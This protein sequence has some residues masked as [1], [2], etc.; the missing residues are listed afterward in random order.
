MS[1]A[2]SPR[3][4]AASA[5]AMLAA[6]AAIAMPPFGSWSAPQNL[7]DLPGSAP[8][9]NTAAVDG[10]VSHD[11][12]GLTLYF[13]SNRD[14][15]HDI[16]M[17]Q[18]ADTSSGFGTPMK[19]PAPINS[20]SHNE[21]CPTIANGNRLYFSSDKDDPAYDLYVSKSGPKGWSAPANLGPNINRPGWLDE[22]ADFYEDEAGSEVMIFSSRSGPEGDIWQSVNGGMRELVPG[23]PHSS[24]SDNRP[25]VTKDGLTIFWD[26]N[27]SGGLGGQDLYFAT[28]SSTSQSFGTAQHLGTLSSPGFDA[29]PVVSW[30]GTFLTFSSQRAGNVSPAPD[31]WIT[32]REKA[33]GN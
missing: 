31:M 4:A 18:R 9:V 28:R 33:V 32:T 23:G 19:L 12:V 27:R 30:D 7:R 26:S 11:K 3:L 13:N 22:T 2:H 17:A 20:S 25:S 24:A 8:N 6:T 15:T 10:C 14:G 29:R 21:S 1:H 5:A 16:Y